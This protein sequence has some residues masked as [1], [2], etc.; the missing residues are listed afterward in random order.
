MVTPRL[1]GPDPD[2]DRDPRGLKPRVS[3]ARDERIGV[4]HR[5]DDAA[6]PGLDDR[7]RA[8]GRGPEMRARLEGCIE[9]RAPRRLAGAVDRDPLGVRP[10][11][12][13][14]RPTPDDRPVL[15]Q[16]RADRGVW[17]GE[18]ERPRSEIERRL[19][20]A[21]VLLGACVFSSAHEAGA[22]LR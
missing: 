19:H 16:D 22:S 21:Q 14:G 15:H 8:R 20:P 18:T 6:D 5:R 7:V 17:G 2:R 10:S 3:L 1:S 9:G 11:P 13:R 12:R 4:L